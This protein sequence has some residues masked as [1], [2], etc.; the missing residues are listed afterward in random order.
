MTDNEIKEYAKEIADK[1]ISDFNNNKLNPEKY[2]IADYAEKQIERDVDEK[3]KTKIINE[4]VKSLADQ[5]YIILN[6]DI[7][8]I[9]KC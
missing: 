7:F 4:F 5:K 9:E 2:G 3:D 6:Q 8:G 1:I